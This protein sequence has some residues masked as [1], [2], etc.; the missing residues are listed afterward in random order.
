MWKTIDEMC[1]R[2]KNLY[3]YAN[4]IIRQSFIND[5]RMIF[6]RELNKELKNIKG[7]RQDKISG[8]ALTYMY[9]YDCNFDDIPYYVKLVSDYDCWIFNFDPDTTYF[10]IGLETEK[11]DALD[12]V[13]KRLSNKDF[14]QSST[15]FSLR[16]VGK[17]IKGFIDKDNEQLRLKFLDIKR[18]L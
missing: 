4:Y 10:K 8:A 16:D 17:I 9:F 6:Y 3:N 14:E 15:T 11:Y 5:G 7:L 12:E 18:W 13:W 2:S 1:F